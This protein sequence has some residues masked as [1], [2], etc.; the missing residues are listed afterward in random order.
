MPPA[1]REGAGQVGVVGGGIGGAA[2]ALA[3]AQRG[4][5]A[6]LLERDAGP[7]VRRQGYGLTMQQ[8]GAALR[9]LG[10]DASALGVATGLHSSHVAATGEQV[11]AY[12]HAVSGGGSGRRRKPRRNNVHVPRTRLRDALLG[13]LEAGAVRWG[14]TLESY[15]ERDDAVI[16][17]LA[18]G[19][20][21]AYACLVGADG[22]YSRVRRQLEP[23]GALEYLGV[24]V[25]LG[26][27]P[28]AHPFA[29]E[30]RVWQSI[31]GDEATRL[32]AMPFDEGSYMWQLSFPMT[33]SEARAL[34]AT[35]GA[36]AQLEV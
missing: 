7:G 11:G 5:H 13:R 20:E 18:D 17:R 26:I 36:G 16:A 10:V 23:E 8:G 14:A 34:T 24:L 22:I 29:A 25:V 21:R 31:D 2:L 30:R 35:G 15:S 19:S 12:G 32:F 6:E 9:A 27:T 33:E 28:L 3:L 4:V 1:P